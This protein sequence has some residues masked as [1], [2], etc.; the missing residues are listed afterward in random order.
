MKAHIFCL[1]FTFVMLLSGCSSKST[2]PADNPTHAQHTTTSTTTIGVTTSTTGESV[3]DTT[4]VDANRTDTTNGIPSVPSHT[5]KAT[6][7]ATS[8]TTNQTSFAAGIS[9]A[10][11]TSTSVTN[12]VTFK[13]TIRENIQNKPVSGVTV[14]V[15]ANG[16]FSPIGTAVTDL[17][18]II[19]IPISK[20]NS[21]RVVLSTLPAGYEADAD[22]RFSTNTVNITIR[23]AAVQNELDHSEAQ[24]EIGKTMTDFSLTDTDGKL[25]RLSDLL[26]EKKLVILNFWFTSCGPCK[27]EF[28]YFETIAQT[29]GEDMTLLAID[30]FDS[31]ASIVALRNELQVTFPMMQDICKLYLGF[32][33]TAFPTTVFINPEGRI[34]DIHIGAYPSEAAFLA[35]IERYMH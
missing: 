23:K 30:P 13:A 26:K 32:D 7:S 31:V 27:M 9:T 25:Y 10:S 34:M 22:Y 29:H 35:A 3:T 24:Y 18:G 2:T 16:G 14:T 33:V 21:Y 1:G 4:T 8:V 15:Y 12:T 6:I 5:K 17:N 19:R 11:T 28:P 20:G